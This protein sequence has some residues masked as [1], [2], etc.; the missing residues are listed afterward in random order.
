MTAGKGVTELF[1]KKG[2]T[3][4]INDNLIRQI[5]QIAVFAFAVLVALLGALISVLGNVLWFRSLALQPCLISGVV[6]GFV[7][8]LVVSTILAQCLETSVAMVFVCFADNA[9]ALKH[10][11]RIEYV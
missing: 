7:V 1:M 3:A 10:H 5:L 8:G 6:V 11:H 2:W 9:E 4:I